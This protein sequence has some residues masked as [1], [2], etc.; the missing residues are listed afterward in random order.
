M[1]DLFRQEALAYQAQRLSGSVSLAQPLSI[2]VLTGLILAT[3]ILSLVFLSF[4]EYAR[5]ETVQGFLVPEQGLIK[6]TSNR[7][8]TVEKIHKSPGDLVQEGEPLASLSAPVSLVVGGELNEALM[9][10]LQRQLEQL[11]AELSQREQ[12]QAIEVKHL[13]SQL[14]KADDLIA[15]YRSQSEHLG[16]RLKLEQEKSSQQDQLFEDGF[17]SSVEVQNQQQTLLLIQQEWENN[18]AEILDHEQQRIDLQSQL[19]RLPFEHEIQLASIRRDMSELRA[20]LVQAESSRQFVVLATKSGTLAASNVNKGEQVEAQDLLFSIT[21][22]GSK[23]VA[24]LLVPSRSAGFIKPGHL[25]RMRLDAFPYQKFGFLDGQIRY[26]ESAPLL[27]GESD[28]PILLS[29]SVYRVT[30]TLSAQEVGTSGEAF[31]LK[32]G[33]LLEADIILEQHSLFSWLFD[34]ITKL[35]RE[36]N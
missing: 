12:L 31:D 25:V 11:T 18:A 32:N 5:K 10:E 15:T 35:N 29:E 14:E 2:Y 23:L 33:M 17:L 4:S 27:P 34:P 1:S 19:E 13:Q 21:P 20:E 28:I 8:G 3:I 22:E 24:E 30:S 16:R 6:I 36:L 9:A 26:V 7:A